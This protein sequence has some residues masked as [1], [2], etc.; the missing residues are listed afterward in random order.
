MRQKFGGTWTDQKLEAL[1]QYLVAYTTIMRGNN[2][3]KHLTATYLDAF[4]GS[5]KYAEKGPN[6]FQDLAGDEATSFRDGSTAIAL[7]VEPGF[8]RFLFI[9]S[10][11]SN[12][13]SLEELKAKHPEMADRIEIVKADINEHLP[14]WCRKLGSTDRVLAFLDPYGM[15]VNWSTLEALAQTGKADV[16]TLVPLGQAIVR[17]LTKGEQ[18][19]EWGAALTRFFGTDEWRD[20]FYP[21]VK[22]ETLF[23][24][25]DI[26]MRDA[27]FGRIIAFVVKRFKTIFPVVL[28]APIVLRNSAKCPLYLLCFA[29]GNPK[30]EKPAL[31]IARHIAK[32]IND[33]I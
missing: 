27:D 16:W 18:P 31:R 2:R 29:A 1:R 6:L 20:E 7:A 10:R 12:V 3:A 17:L 8:D 23:G 4:A 22:T 9:D 32:G 28:D 25:E 19:P 30:A 11:Q 26:P 13:A 14:G 24:E 15:Q 21:K 33:G 5:G